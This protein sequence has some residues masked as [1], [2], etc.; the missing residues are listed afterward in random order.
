LARKEL[1]RLQKKAKTFSLIPINDSRTN[2]L[3]ERGNDT[4]RAMKKQSDT[5]YDVKYTTVKFNDK[6]RNSKS[7]HWIGMKFYVG[8]PDMISNLGLNF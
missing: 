6:S 5:D 7:D 2:H 1:Q 4:N 8:S 3:E